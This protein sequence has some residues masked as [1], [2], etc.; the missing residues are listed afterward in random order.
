MWA[1]LRRWI[2]EHLKRRSPT[3]D[4]LV[5]MRYIATIA[6]LCPCKDDF[7]VAIDKLREIQSEQQEA[8]PRK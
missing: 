5:Y 1:A 8:P 7:N 4:D 3:E 2:G 6:K